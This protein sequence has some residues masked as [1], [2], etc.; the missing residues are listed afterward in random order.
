MEIQVIGRNSEKPYAWY[1]KKFGTK[2]E[3]F[4]YIKGRNYYIIKSNGRERFIPGKCCKVTIPARPH[5][6]ILK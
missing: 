5:I 1:N 3:V 2:Y 6:I 4:K